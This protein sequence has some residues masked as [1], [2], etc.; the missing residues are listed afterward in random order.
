[1]RRLTEIP[2]T[3]G[4]PPRF[5][6]LF[7]QHGDLA[8]TLA[9]QLDV[10]AA[11]VTCSGT[12]ALMLALRVAQQR[13]PERDVVVVP[14]Y[15]CPLVAIAVHAIG[16]RLR[17][18][19][20]RHDSLDMD[21]YAL[22]AQLDERVLAVVPTHLGGR[23]TDVAAVNRVVA[24]SGIVVIEDAAQSLGATINGRSVGLRGDIGFF[25]LAAGK[26]LSTYEGGVAVARDRQWLEAMRA[27]QDALPEQAAM[28]RKRCVELAGYTA[29]YRPLGMRWAYGLPL[30]RALKR[31][32]PVG[33]IG[34]RFPMQVPL[35]RMGAWRKRIGANAALRLPRFL[36]ERCACALARIERLHAIPGAQVFGDRAGEHGTWPT[37][38]VRMDSE[39]RRDAVL[40]KLWTSGLGASRMFIHALPDYTE[41]RAI[42]P[43]QD[44][45]NARDLAARSFT[46]SNSPWLRDEDFEAICRVI[47]AIAA[48]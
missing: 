9:T 23:V 35:H 7:A 41:L 39:H 24:D 2:P 12:A 16:L 8:A 30:R 45:P 6:D 47:E 46:I 32:D 20:L 38:L 40:D 22:R 15:T 13:Q 14:A 33:A 34:D 5:S 25:S 31:G 4:L 29:L 18:V 36:E 37:L 3:A 19:D 26:G 44:C 21:E 48:S 10:D 1:M 42:V 43:Q 27:L 11:L 28:E 17:I